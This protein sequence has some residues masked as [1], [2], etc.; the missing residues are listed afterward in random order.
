V[1]SMFHALQTLEEDLLHGARRSTAPATSRQGAAPPTG[2][3]APQVPGA[4]RLCGSSE[5]MPSSCGPLSP[6]TAASAWVQGALAPSSG[7]YRQTMA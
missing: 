1:A 7:V 6:T 3:G 5:A 2:S 4:W